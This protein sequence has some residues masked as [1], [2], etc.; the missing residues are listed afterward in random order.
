MCHSA[1]PFVYYI[2]ASRSQCGGYGIIPNEC[3]VETQTGG[4][5]SHYGYQRV[6]YRYLAHWIARKQFVVKRKA[7]RGDT[8]EHQQVKEANNGDVRQSTTHQQAWNHQQGTTD[9]KT[10]ARSDKHIHTPRYTSRHQSCT[11]TAQCIEDNHAVAKQGEGTAFLAAQIQCEDT[12]KTDGTAYTI[13][14][15]QFVAL[16]EQAG[17]E[18]QHKHTQRVQDG[19]TTALTV[20]QSNVET[21]IVQRR[22]QKRERQQEQH[23]PPDMG[24]GG[25]LQAKRAMSHAS[26]RKDDEA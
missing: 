3:L 2:D 15:S 14:E 11:G 25:F 13:S 5:G 22:V 26:D 8:D 24:F 12:R 20:R 18:D 7:Y 6:P 9:A 10:V 1:F 19:G 16:E 4:D 21:G 17:K 23:V